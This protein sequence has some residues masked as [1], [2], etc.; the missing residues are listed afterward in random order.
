MVSSGG[1]PAE[2]GGWSVG[3]KLQSERRDEFWS[4]TENRGLQARMA[5]GASPKSWY[6]EDSEH[7]YQKTYLPSFEY[8]IVCKCIEIQL[9]S[10]DG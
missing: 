9:Y 1:N 2:E 5:C 6:G 10:Q 8:Y 4:S 3:G 7:F